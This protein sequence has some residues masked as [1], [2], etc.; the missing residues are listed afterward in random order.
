MHDVTNTYGLSDG[1]GELKKAKIEP[2][3]AENAAPETE[4]TTT[5]T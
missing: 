3:N 4:H 1:V 2:T 5:A